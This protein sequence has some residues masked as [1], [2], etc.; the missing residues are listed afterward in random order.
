MLTLF[1]GDAKFPGGRG[2]FIAP[3]NDFL[4]F[5]EGPTTD[6]LLQWRTYYDAADEAGISRLYGGIHIASDDLR[7][8]I[9]GS[10]VGASAFRRARQYFTTSERIGN[11][12]TNL[13]TRGR[14]GT[15]EATMILGFVINGDATKPVLMRGA[16]PALADLGV[17]SASTN[18]TINLYASGATTP[19][20]TN[21][22]WAETNELARLS[23]IT[24]D[25]GAFT[26]HGD[27]NDAAILSDLSSGAY[28][29]Q[30]EGDGGITLAEIYDAANSD[31]GQLINLS[32][33][34]TVGSGDH[35]LIAGF[36]VTG[37]KPVQ[38]LIRAVGPTLGSFGILNPSPQPSVK[39]IR[40]STPT[41][42]VIAEN[43]NWM[44]HPAASAIESLAQQIG[45][46]PL[47]PHAED[48]ALLITLEPGVYTAQMADDSL[49]E[50]GIGL[51]EIYWIR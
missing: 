20:Q 43:Q 36:V 39:L 50:P 48:S 13:S 42:T 5:E 21:A 7:G 24:V 22:R 41:R 31:N 2:E 11:P 45:S 40:Q 17:I 1:T 47:E 16:G 26:F 4:V 38:V 15:G 27:S 8:R 18:P 29:L 9:V 46:F 44:T 12:I 33:R 32:T 35:S 19:M 10:R 51:L 3:Q 6:V 34:G 28:T 49:T 37:T 23:Q 25:V 30:I 14:I